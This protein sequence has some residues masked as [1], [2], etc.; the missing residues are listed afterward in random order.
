MGKYGSSNSSR[1]I[2]CSDID[3]YETTSTSEASCSARLLE[4]Q[5]VGALN[6]VSIN[7]KRV[8]QSRN[9]NALHVGSKKKCNCNILRKLQIDKI[10]QNI[11]QQREFHNRRMKVA[12]A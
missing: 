9:D 4:R 8:L 2:D 3:E 12:M 5:N 10:K 6:K 1:E 7:N 11:E